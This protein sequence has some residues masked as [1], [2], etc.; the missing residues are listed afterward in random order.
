MHP[1]IVRSLIF[2]LH[3]RLRGRRTLAR[4]RQLMRTD[5]AP[6]DEL[7]VLQTC[8]LR[9]LL[10][11]AD[12][13]CPG[14]RARIRAAG[15]DPAR[16]ELADLERIEP[17]DKEAIRRLTPDDAANHRPLCDERTPGGLRRY[18]TGGSS[19]EP[20]IFYVDA[21]R[22]ADDLAAWVRSRRWFGIDI[23]ARELY[24][25]GAP[26]ELTAQDRL[27]AWRDRAGNHRL[28]SAFEMSPARM[29]AY[30]DEI[31]RFNPVHI[32]GYP[33]SLARLVA[34]ARRI[35]RPSPGRSLRVIFV[36]GETLEPRDRA[37]IGD[38]FNVPVADGYGS[39][40][41]GFLAH[42]CPAGRLHVTM[43]SA[44]VELLDAGGHPVRGD[45]IGEVTV[46]HLQ[47][48]G[49]PF[50]RYR[51]GDLARWERR[52]CPCGR[53]HETLAAIE[54]RRGDEI[55]L[56]DGAMAHHLSA[57]YPLRE[58][59][60]IER[61]DVLQ[62]ASLGLEVRIVPADGFTA[63]DAARLRESLRRQ[64]RGLLPIDLQ[65]TSELPA[66]ASGKYRVVRSEAV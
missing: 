20:L 30:L 13:A 50:I 19:G 11:H 8:G 65:I 37:A 56:P 14:H 23:G 3:E 32:F 4:L 16:A 49:M 36:T 55:R 64:F 60:G 51:T 66:A 31:G 38:Y 61:F 9:T 47:T 28:L 5:R 54:G 26:V 62:R 52:L 41:A 53:G 27:R 10:R 59:R 45:E 21:R 57:L 44:V 17:I 35:G 46:T 6:L 39:R 1:A 25:W 40:E 63:E 18:T 48:Y 24:L 58:C 22:Q 7:R 15:I 12:R 42:E 43:E 2:P 34:H 29:D 33:S